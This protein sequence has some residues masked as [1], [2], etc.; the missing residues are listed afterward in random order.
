MLD[1]LRALW[2][3]WFGP[4]RDGRVFNRDALWIVEDME[5]GY[6]VED[7]RHVARIT[8]REIASFHEALAQGSQ[9]YA[10]SIADLRR[11]HRESKR[12]RDAISLTALTLVIIYL[13]AEA[14]DEPG[15]PARAEIDAFIGRWQHAID[16]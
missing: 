13:K 10:A 9:T 4:E 7:M 11:H 3:S 2:L 16:Q 12:L 6:S 15:Q 8:A 5:R 14:I 1:L